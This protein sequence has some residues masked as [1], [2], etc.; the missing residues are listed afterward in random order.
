[1][2]TFKAIRIIVIHELIFINHSETH[3]KSNDSISSQ[4]LCK[5]TNHGSVNN[6]QN[7]YLNLYDV[8]LEIIE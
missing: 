7:D 8:A 2:P 6:P 4:D 1:M 5:T 3:W